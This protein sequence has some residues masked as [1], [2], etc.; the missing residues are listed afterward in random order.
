MQFMRDVV[1]KYLP[2]PDA[3]KTKDRYIAMFA[4]PLA[5][6]LIAGIKM[7]MRQ[8]AGEE[9]LVGPETY[10][11][12]GLAAVLFV[13]LAIP[14]TFPHFYLGVMRTL[15][16]VGFIIS[17]LV[18]TLT[19]YIPISLMGIVLRMTGKDFLDW[20]RV[21]KKPSWHKHRRH[22]ERRSYFRQF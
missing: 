4:W 22:V 1:W 14:A 6:L 8:R 10:V 15:S 7:W 2:A 13:G 17:N 21:D 20:R 11:L 9:V 16:I 19:Y 3:I 18:L 5:L 12:G